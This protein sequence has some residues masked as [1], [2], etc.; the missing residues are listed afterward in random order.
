MRC[1]FQKARA[2]QR[3]VR[4]SIMREAPKKRASSFFDWVVD[5]AFV[6]S[7]EDGLT[8]RDVSRSN[9]SRGNKKGK[10][11]IDSSSKGRLIDES[12]DEEDEIEFD[13]TDTNP[14]HDSQMKI[15]KIFKKSLTKMMVFK[16]LSSSCQDETSLA[17]FC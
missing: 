14:Y 17:L 13:E 4:L 1:N 15:S 3:F 8:Y 11:A 6:F 2:F 5:W 10:N 9:T 12:E 16:Y 7:K